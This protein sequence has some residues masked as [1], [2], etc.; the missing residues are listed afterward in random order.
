MK[1]VE[2]ALQVLDI[3]GSIEKLGFDPLDDTKVRT[4]QSCAQACH[5]GCAH[6][7]KGL[8]KRGTLYVPL[9]VELS[10]LSICVMRHATRCFSFASL[11]YG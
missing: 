9:C 2:C 3:E 5:V 4:G 7:S 11:V 6:C 10:C 8:L 1:G